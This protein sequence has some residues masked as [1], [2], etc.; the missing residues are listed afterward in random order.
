MVKIFT[1]IFFCTHPY[2]AQAV[3]KQCGEERFYLISGEERSYLTCLLS[4]FDIYKD[5]NK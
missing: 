1:Q 5:K 2:K 3:I 4:T